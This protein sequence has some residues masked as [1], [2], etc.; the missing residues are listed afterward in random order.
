M[1][2]THNPLIQ[3]ISKTNYFSIKL[4]YHVFQINLFINNNYKDVFIDEWEA[5]LVEQTFTVYET[6]EI[7]EVISYYKE[8]KGD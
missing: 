7:Q 1:D 6:G 2:A 4:D 8:Q 3:I 5:S